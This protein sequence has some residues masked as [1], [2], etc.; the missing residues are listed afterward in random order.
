MMAGKFQRTPRLLAINMLITL[1][2]I[3][4]VGFFATDTRR[5]FEHLLIR[6]DITGGLMLL[7]V[8][9]VGANLSRLQIDVDG[10]VLWVARQ[11]WLIALALWGLLSLGT[12]GLYQSHPLSMDE[13]AA[14]FQ[15]AIFANGSLTTHLPPELVDRVVPKG[16]QGHF[17][18]ANAMTGEVASAY[19]PGF[20]LLLA[21]FVWLGIPWACNPLVVAI[22]LLLIGKIAADIFNDE[23]ARG[24]AMLFALASPAFTLNGISFYSMP[25]HLLFNLVFA[26]L[27]LAPSAI[28]VFLAGVVGSY[29]LI[30]HNPFPHLLFALPWL[31]W[32]I[33]RRNG[34]ARNALLLA[35]GYL[36]LALLVGVGWIHS[37]EEVRRTGMAIAHSSSAAND[38]PWILRTIQGLAR[39]FSIPDLFTSM[40]RI[41]ELAKLWLWSS[42]FI[43]VFAW[44]AANRLGGREMH[45]LG[46]SM[47]LTFLGYFLVPVDQG[48]GW[49]A[50]YLHSAWGV[51]PIL[52]AAWIYQPESTTNQNAGN[53]SLVMRTLLLSLVAVVGLRAWQIGDFMERHLAQLP[54]Y[55]KDRSSIVFVLRGYYAADLVQNDP[56]LRKQPWIFVTRGKKEDR[57]L[58]GRLLPGATMYFSGRNGWSYAA[59][60][61]DVDGGAP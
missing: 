55:P 34:G 54:Q 42:P 29:A 32:L 56:W 37:L 41:A 49:G 51:L 3:A 39:V 4:F 53:S 35:A 11:R 6:H 25:A 7:A 13:Y 10:L 36:P 44:L 26:W 24:W 27:L 31:G 18:I 46:A 45:L 22:S 8:I 47:L 5:I 33:F 40:I 17:L 23:R 14:S 19:W 60:D 52:A 59:P 30:L 1:G 28:R 58:A 12:V 38:V 48:H 2:A 57:E 20:A 16:F 43:L 9:L 21:P 50:R 15:A 61:G